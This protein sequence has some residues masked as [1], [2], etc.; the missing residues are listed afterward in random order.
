MTDKEDNSSVDMRM[1]FRDSEFSYY[2]G[3]P[4]ISEGS[5][6]IMLNDGK[7]LAEIFN[8]NLDA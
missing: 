6:A 2:K 3:H 1:E 4:K 7:I 5:G 8:G